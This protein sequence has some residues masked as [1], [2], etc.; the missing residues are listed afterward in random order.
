MGCADLTPKEGQEC[1][2]SVI[3][4]AGPLDTSRDT[5]GGILTHFLC[6]MMGLEA[7]QSAYGADPARALT[8][9]AQTP[10]VAGADAG[11]M[12]TKFGTVAMAALKT[13]GERHAL[14]R[15]L[16]IAHCSLRSTRPGSLACRTCLRGHARGIRALSAGASAPRDHPAGT[17]KRMY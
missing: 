6:G 12:L 14:P 2:G 5:Q 11:L 16:R 3:I 10:P 7:L 15:M 1:F 9:L 17:A 4:M 13:H 8:A